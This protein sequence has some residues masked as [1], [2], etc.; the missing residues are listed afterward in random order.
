M[1]TLRFAVLA[2]AV[3]GALHAQETTPP[4]AQPAA[5]FGVDALRL[6]QSSQAT[7][8]FEA[9]VRCVVPV[10]YKLQDETAAPDVD[11]N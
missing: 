7:P 1:K 3:S 6:V 10:R 2:L 8:G 9:G 11:Q 4:E 5:A